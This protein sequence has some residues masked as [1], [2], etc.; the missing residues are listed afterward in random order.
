MLGDR[1]L[2]VSEVLIAR[3]AACEEDSRNSAA[4]GFLGL[5]ALQ[6]GDYLRLRRCEPPDLQSQLNGKLTEG[7]E[8]LEGNGERVDWRTDKRVSEITIE[9][10]AENT[11]R[12]L[13]RALPREPLTGPLRGSLE[14]TL[15]NPLGE[16]SRGPFELDLAIADSWEKVSRSE[17]GV[18]KAVPQVPL[19]RIGIVFE[20]SREIIVG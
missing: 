11:Y 7:M 1:R 20:R 17:G 12:G 13:L 5:R 16:S 3:L 19:S 10:T 14:A 8:F 9:T 6:L 4:V 18:G 2:Y 15:R